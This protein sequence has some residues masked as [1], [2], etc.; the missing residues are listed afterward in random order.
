MG[1]V[2]AD[3]VEGQRPACSAVRPVA[4]E[5]P[6]PYEGERVVAQAYFD[7]VE[8]V[9]SSAG[10][11][12]QGAPEVTGLCQH[13]AVLGGDLRR[14]GVAV[15]LVTMMLFALT[16]VPSSTTVPELGEARA[17]TIR[18]SDA[19]SAATVRIDAGAGL[20]GYATPMVE[21]AKGGTLSVINF[22]STRHSVTS[23]DR[24]ASGNPLFSALR[25][26][27]WTA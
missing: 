12:V 18:L 21:L 10:D 22:D 26:R 7:P 13:R 23:D 19:P 1:A 24:D 20:G 4:V 17:G 3:H 8:T 6:P 11:P 15:V 27:R 14:L 9:A 5:A 25:P 2:T 16:V